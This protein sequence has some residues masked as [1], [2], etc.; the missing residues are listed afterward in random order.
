MRIIKPLILFFLLFST[1]AWA[2]NV[3]RIPLVEHF[4]NTHCGICSNKNPAMFNTLSMY[5]GEVHHIAYHPPYPYTDCLFY[6]DNKTENQ[7]RSD[8]YNV[9]GSPR[10]YLNGERTSGSLLLPESKLTDALELTSP[11]QLIL[12]ENQGNNRNVDVTVRT[13]GNMPSGI[14]KLYLAVVESEIDYDAPNGETLHHDVFRRFVNNNGPQGQLINMPA[15]G[16]EVSFSFNYTLESNWK[17]EEIYVLAFIQNEDD[18]SIVNA[19][20][21]SDQNV[22]STQELVDE[23]FIRVSPNPVQTQ[24]NILSTESSYRLGQVD[25][26]N[27]AGQLMLSFEALSSSEYTRDL[28]LTT[29]PSGVYFLKIQTDKGSFIKKIIK[30]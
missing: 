11:V 1:S 23:R 16:Q 25:L 14:Y 12:S 30:G 28:N 2:Q 8:Y 4:T 27:T 3:K 22:S 9:S 6:N 26:F 15:T 29:L 20:A 24:L 5:E 17:A 7:S 18:K 10:V 13:V 21:A 19:A